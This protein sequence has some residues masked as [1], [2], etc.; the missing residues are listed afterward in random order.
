KK[1]WP[2]YLKGSHSLSRRRF[3]PTLERSGAA[4]YHAF[5]SNEADPHAREALLA[6]AAR[7]EENACL[8]TTCASVSD[9]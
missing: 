6:A 8:L 9:S 1:Q 2:N 3:F 7:E 4:L 5:A